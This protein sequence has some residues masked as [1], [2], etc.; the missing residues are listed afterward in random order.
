LDDFFKSKKKICII[1]HQTLIS[2]CSSHSI[3][4]CNINIDEA[5]HISGTNN[6]G[7]L[8][9]KLIDKGTVGIT[10]TTATFFRGDTQE[11][12][13]DSTKAL[14]T[15]F[16]QDV[17]EYIAGLEYLK[18]IELSVQLYDIATPF[19]YIKQNYGGKKTIIYIPNVN[20][21]EFKIIGSKSKW[22]HGCLTALSHPRSKNTGPDENGVYTIKNGGERK[23]LDL[24]TNNVDHRK[25]AKA[26]LIKN[27]K[28]KTEIDVI[29]ALGMMKE[30]AN[31]EAAEKAIVFNS[32]NLNELVQ[33]LGRIIRD[34]EHKYKAELITVVPKNTITSDVSFKEDINNYIKATILSM[35]I[36]D[37]I[38]PIALTT[39]EKK[40]GLGGSTPSV[41]AL[42]DQE[43]KA[44]IISEA[45]EL[46]DC[47]TEAEMKE[48]IIEIVNNNISLPAKDVSE[49]AERII[50]LN[51]KKTL[52]L[53]GI[54]V[55][56]IDY[57][58]IKRS[59]VHPLGWLLHG[60]GDFGYAD[61]D[62]LRAAWNNGE[63]CTHEEWSI[64][65]KELQIKGQT[66]YNARYKEDDRLHSDPAKYYEDW[67]GWRKELKQKH[68]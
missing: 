63:K 16:N 24:I 4:N 53:D 43:I 7:K 39:A 23:V 40:T 44:T 45:S 68:N 17:Q 59:E 28:T 64:I 35:I 33:I 61:F 18:N 31:F 62:S 50:A 49:I 1:S 37:F 52:Q 11:I 46:I 36:D 47:D 10:L 9:K 32:R 13:D 66:D 14:F 56:K 54:D 22:I 42:M 34:A 2:Y 65:V 21:T 6:I 8:L 15:R 20:S 57:D 19:D 12:L 55:S 29:L 5:H 48:A 41:W 51:K 25:N 26:H 60:T 38:S 67:K 3:S 30:G 58:I 27:Q